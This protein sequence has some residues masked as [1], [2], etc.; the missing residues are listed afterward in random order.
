MKMNKMRKVINTKPFIVAVA[1][2]ATLAPIIFYAFRIGHA[3]TNALIFNGFSEALLAVMVANAI[4]M[5][6]YA[7]RKVRG[8]SAKNSIVYYISAI[9]SIIFL[10][11]NL[12]FAII[13]PDD[14]KVM[15]GF[16]IELLP[17]LWIAFGLLFLLFVF[18]YLAPRMQ[19]IVSVVLI[20][21][22]IVIFAIPAFISLCPFAFASEPLV[23]D[24]G[25]EYI[26]IWAT[27]DS[28]TG[29]V[30]YSYE[31]ENYKI[32]QENGG[33]LVT[34]RIHNIKV[35]YEH[36]NN[37]TYSVHSAR[38]LTELSY[39]GKLG[40]S[41][42]SRKYHF[43]GDL[44]QKANIWALTDWHCELRAVARA[45]SYLD[46]P[47]L[48]LMLGDYADGYNRLNDIIKYIIAGG[49]QVTNSEVAVIFAMGN[50][51]TRG[52]VTSSLGNIL[53]ME[54]FYYQ[55]DKGDFSFLVTDSGEDKP[56]DHPEYGG[57]VAF[58]QFTSRQLQ[59]ISG[60]EPMDNKYIIGISHD[61]EF[62][63][64]DQLSE[65][66]YAEAKRLGI[67]LMLSG[68]VHRSEFLE[69]KHPIPV[70]V[71]GGKNGVKLKGTL[72]YTATQ[73][74]I[75]DNIAKIKAVSDKGKIQLEKD[76]YF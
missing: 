54:Q 51:D 48:V 20:V 70:L 47:D 44:P 73:L 61:E 45:T 76:F 14:I 27:N 15:G 28:S 4:F 46:R 33:R 65:Q 3:F 36:L 49:A 16:L 75:N 57:V 55:V 72:S 11:V 40:K 71:V 23:L 7:Y 34:E 74:T 2:I 26:I 13:F 9:A 59:W 41:I 32:Y 19:K 69:D 67:K 66:Y 25:E 39:G 52:K 17:W 21:V 37:N 43:R 62:N 29:Y 58:D 50:H 68:H 64:Q 42:S 30:E 18:P 35:P 63:Y 1:L 56:D 12:V 31:G 5:L 53:G 38:V 24:N 6:I 8:I 10:L 22:I 60:L